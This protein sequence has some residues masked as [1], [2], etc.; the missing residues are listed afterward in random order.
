[1]Y[2]LGYKEVQKKKQKKKTT[3]SKDIKSFWYETYFPL[4]RVIF[5]RKT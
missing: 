4:T 1:M 2:D 5:S 3:N